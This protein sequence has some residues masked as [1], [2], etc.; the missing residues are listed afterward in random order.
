MRH[1]LKPGDKITILVLTEVETND[2]D[3][4]T[5]NDSENDLDIPQVFVND[6]LI[7]CELDSEKGYFWEDRQ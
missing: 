6:E 4:F 1:Y 5:I 2:A 3:G 7:P